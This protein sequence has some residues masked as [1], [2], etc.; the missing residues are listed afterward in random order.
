MANSEQATNSHEEAVA[1]VE[2]MFGGGEEAVEEQVE[3]AE[4]ETAEAE[5][6]EQ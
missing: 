2:K 3:T 4:A 1:G 5:A 6:T